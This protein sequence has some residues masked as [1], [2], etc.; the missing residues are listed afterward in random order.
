MTKVQ[1]DF[2]EDIRSMQKLR[3]RDR[4]DYDLILQKMQEKIDQN[5]H[6]LNVNQTYF[7][8]FASSISLL[9]ENINLQ[10]E[11]DMADFNDRNLMSL[12]GANSANPDPSDHQKNPLIVQKHNKHLVRT[13]GNNAT[14]QT[15]DNEIVNLNITD[16]D[17]NVD[18]EDESDK[19]QQVVEDS[20][21]DTPELRNHISGK[22]IVKKASTMKP[23]GSIA[24]DDYFD[25]IRD[26]SGKE[27]LRAKLPITL[28]HKCLSHSNNAHDRTMAM[29]LFKVACLAYNPA[30]VNYRDHILERGEVI[31]MRRNM[32]D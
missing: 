5:R 9:T 14:F 24:K 22:D 17:I 26:T 20:I 3:A 29:K 11:S 12:Y 2:N 10:M 31:A 15:T 13:G 27:I 32:V 4:S 21:I 30:K 19:S 23:M 18:N 7:E 8:T 25:P 6:L 28:D 1:A 16:K